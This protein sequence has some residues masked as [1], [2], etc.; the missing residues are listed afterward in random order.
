MC[1]AIVSWHEST[2]VNRVHFSAGLRE[3]DLFQLATALQKVFIMRLTWLFTPTRSRILAAMT[4]GLALLLVPTAASAVTLDQVVAMSKAGVSEP[5]IVA[6]IERDGTVFTIEPDQIVTL[7]KAGLSDSLIMTMLKS[8]RAEG[9]AAARADAASNANSIAATLSPAPE[10]VIVG[11]GPD[12]P[13]T[14]HYNGF[15]SGPPVAPF[16]PLVY[17]YPAYGVVGAYGI[18]VARPR[19]PRAARHHDDPPATPATQ[20]VKR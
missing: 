17:G 3:P 19:P 12:I 4:W 1:P 18:P 15:Y 8:G 7:Q 11:H 13:D 9:D 5:V 10:V 20:A 6:V 16:D 2:L 14:V